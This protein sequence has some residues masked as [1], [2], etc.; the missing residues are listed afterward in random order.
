[1]LISFDFPPLYHCVHISS[2]FCSDPIPRPPDAKRGVGEHLHA[3]SGFLHKTG[4]IALTSAALL[5][6]RNTLLKHHSKDPVLLRRVST[7]IADQMAAEEA[8]PWVCPCGRL[9]KKTSNQCALCWGHWVQR[10]KTRCYSEDKVLWGQQSLEQLLGCMG[11]R[12]GSLGT[13]LGRYRKCGSIVTLLTR[14]PQSDVRLFPRS[15]PS[16][17]KR[18]GKAK[19]KARSKASKP[20][21]HLG[22][23]KV[24]LLRYLHGLHGAI[25]KRWSPPSSHPNPA[26]T[27][28]CKR[29]L[30]TSGKLSEIKKPCRCSGLSRKGGEGVQPKQY[31]IVTGC[32]KKV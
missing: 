12:L 23:A 11:P 31:Q 2:R 20:P 6:V 13:R 3:G 19:E 5:R 8:Y 30:C 22:Q 29:W 9:N 26:G 10:I 18:K 1:M 25:R 15:R 27:I 21:V 4:R 32:Y 24:V 7:V 28:P 17:G 16:K 14:T